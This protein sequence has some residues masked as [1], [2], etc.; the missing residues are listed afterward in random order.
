MYY[1]FLTERVVRFEMKNR[2]K[3]VR[4]IEQTQSISQSSM[5]PDHVA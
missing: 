2:A 4:R 5:R 1:M 3:I